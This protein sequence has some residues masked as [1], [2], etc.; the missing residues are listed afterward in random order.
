MDPTSAP[1]HRMDRTK[2]SLLNVSTDQ[3]YPLPPNEESTEI[4]RVVVR[5]SLSGDLAR[6]LI[7][8]ILE[9]YGI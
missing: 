1:I 8:D 6:R 2:V 7:K 4:L 5:E 3:S 9:V